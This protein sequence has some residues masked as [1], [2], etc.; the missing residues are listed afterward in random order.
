[1]SA[2]VGAGQTRADDERVLHILHVLEVQGA[3]VAR[4]RFGLTNSAVQ[5]MRHRFLR[6]D[7]VGGCAC[8]RP[9]NRDGGMP[10]DWWRRAGTC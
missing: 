2:R 1:M 9:E 10:A 7:A 3:G 4:A 5:G 8:D 6:R